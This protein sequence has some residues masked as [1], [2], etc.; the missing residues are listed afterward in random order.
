MSLSVFGE[1]DGEALAVTVGDAFAELGAAPPC[2]VHAVA[3]AT[4]MIKTNAAP[5][6]MVADRRR[7]RP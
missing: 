6:A 4:E 1:A 7:G 3:Q 5:M 2:P